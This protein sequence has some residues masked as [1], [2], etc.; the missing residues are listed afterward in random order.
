MQYTEFRFRLLKWKKYKVNDSLYIHVHICRY[1][2]S[3]HDTKSFDPVQSR[4]CVS[5]IMF[6]P[7][8]MLHF[9]NNGIFFS[10][11]S[12]L[13]IMFIWPYYKWEYTGRFSCPTFT[14]ASLIFC[15]LVDSSSFFVVSEQMISKK[16]NAIYLFSQ[17]WIRNV[18]RLETESKQQKRREKTSK[19]VNK[20]D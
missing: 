17:I 19:L 8:F 3:G 5:K 2:L 15:L 18:N 4:N 13:E 7:S 11:L 16:Q 1:N 6:V 14:K 20:K 12:R 10:N 9:R